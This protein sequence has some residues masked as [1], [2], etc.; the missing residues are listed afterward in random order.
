[1]VTKPEQMLLAGMHRFESVS[2]LSNK[3]KSQCI[4]PHV[5]GQTLGGPL[6]TGMIFCMQF[7]SPHA[8]GDTKWGSFL[9]RQRATIHVVG[10]IQDLRVFKY[11]FDNML[12]TVPAG[13]TAYGFA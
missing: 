2:V 13:T 12:V 7:V 10:R 6:H 3:F 9:D 11:H 5:V 1:M 8:R 4:E